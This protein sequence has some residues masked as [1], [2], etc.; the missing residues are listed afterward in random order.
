MA[1]GLTHPLT[2]IS[3]R[4]LPLGK[5]RPER[6]T[7][8]LIPIC[9]PIVYKMWRRRRLTTLWALT[10]CYKNSFTFYPSY[11]TH[12]MSGSLYPPRSDRLKYTVKFLNVCIRGAP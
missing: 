1:L 11:Y 2:V 10:A 7:N 9:K 3:T 4:N 6:K 8:N 12:Y 5:E